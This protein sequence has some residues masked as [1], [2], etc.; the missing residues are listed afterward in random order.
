MKLL[1]KSCLVLL[2]SAV[3]LVATAQDWTELF[4]GKNFK[5]WKQIGGEAKYE[6][7]DGV[8]VGTAVAKTP[9]SFMTTKEHYSDFVLEYEVWVDPTV[10]SGVQIRSNS[11]PEYNNGRVHGYQ[12]E[13]DPSARGYSGGIY[14]EARRGWMYP[15]SLN[16]K[17]RTA[18]KNGQWNKI[19][20]EAIGNTIRTW[21]NGIQCANLV[22]DLTASGFIGLQVHSVG[23][24]TERIG[25]QIK[26]KNIRIAT[27]NFDA[28]RFAQDPNVPEASFLVN[29]LTGSEKRKGWRLLWDGKTTSGWRGA[30][31]TAFPDKGWEIKDGMISVMKSTGGEAENGGDIVT[32]GQYGAFDLQF[33]FKL[34]EGANSGVKYF[35]T[36]KEGNRATVRVSGTINFDGQLFL[37]KRGKKWKISKKED[38]YAAQKTVASPTAKKEVVSHTEQKKAVS[39]TEQTTSH[40]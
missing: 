21:I 14:D 8:V 22:D 30:N 39:H 12:V 7:V 34:T 18:F 25:S 17:A 13:L 23:N 24:K 37:V 9:N 35:V 5:G 11:L 15:L 10:N 29:K 1:Y 3:S 26:W 2:I 36:E 31:K 33:E 20:V 38:L 16:P 19:H 28:V 40:K 27:S 32:E 4:N 6:V